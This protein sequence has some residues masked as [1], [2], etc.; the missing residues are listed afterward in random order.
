MEPRG[1]RDRQTDRQTV[2]GLH[3]Q[4]GCSRQQL[5]KLVC[6]EEGENCSFTSGQHFTLCRRAVRTPSLTLLT[7]VCLCSVTQASVPE[8]EGGNGNVQFKVSTTI[9]TSTSTRTSSVSS[10]S[11]TTLFRTPYGSLSSATW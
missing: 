7:P 6:Q 9:S 11:T 2:S 3:N 4:R 8:S 5:D 1:E 10:T